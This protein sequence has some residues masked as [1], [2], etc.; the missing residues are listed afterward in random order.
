MRESESWKN[1]EGKSTD[2]TL[3]GASALR[4]ASAT[5]DESGGFAVRWQILEA[6]EAPP[7]EA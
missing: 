1:F 6:V 7:V 3:T 4:S 5:R 2:S